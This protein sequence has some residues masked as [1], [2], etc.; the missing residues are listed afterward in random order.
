MTDEQLQRRKDIFEMRHRNKLSFH[1]I[2]FVYGIS[3]TRAYAIYQHY[4]RR[5]RHPDATGPHADLLRE[6]WA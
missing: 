1:A 2:G 5:L 4:C 6:Y 3:R